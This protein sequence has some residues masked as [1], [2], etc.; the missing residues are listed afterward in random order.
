[1]LVHTVCP[2]PTRTDRMASLAGQIAKNRGITPEEAEASLT[3]DVPMGRMGRPEEVA[4]LGLLPGLGTP[5]LLDRAHAG[6]RRRPGQGIALR[7]AAM[8]VPNSVE[9]HLLITISPTWFRPVGV[10]GHEQ[11]ATVQR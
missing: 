2:G 5:Q 4:D 9:R 8:D 11:Y 6:R 7:K 10:Q 3:A 1:M